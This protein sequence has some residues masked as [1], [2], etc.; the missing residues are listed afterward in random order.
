VYT[1]AMPKALQGREPVEVGIRDLRANLSR[2]LREVR[3]GREVVV[4]DRG[5]PVARLLPAAGRDDPLA[6]LIARGLASPPLAPA[7]P[8][9]PRRLPKPD[10]S[11]TEILLAMRDGTWT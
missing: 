2:W 3:S 11:V 5:E 4:T 10:G 1:E 8:V 9:D 6:D 7:E